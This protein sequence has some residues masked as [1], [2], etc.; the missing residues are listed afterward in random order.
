M[1]STDSP[2]SRA[3]VKSPVVKGQQHNRY[4][5]LSTTGY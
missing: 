3:F 4:D 1:R 5:F 2:E